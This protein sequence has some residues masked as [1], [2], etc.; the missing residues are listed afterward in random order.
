MRK[1]DDLMTTTNAPRGW[2]RVVGTENTWVNE[3]LGLAAVRSC[4]LFVLSRLEGGRC[5]SALALATLADFGLLDAEE[6]VGEA[7]SRA[8]RPR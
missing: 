3:G 1:A 2:V 6:I 5:G 4:N 7:G 8:F